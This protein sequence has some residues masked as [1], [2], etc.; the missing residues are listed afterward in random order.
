MQPSL[1]TLALLLPLA[2]GAR[3]A[4]APRVVRLD[5]LALTLTLP[6]LENLASP[7]PN[8]WRGVLSG[9]QVEIALKTVPSDKYDLREPEDVLEV[10]PSFWRNPQHERNDP[11]TRRAMA[12]PFGYA[13][14]ASYERTELASRDGTTKV[15]LRFLLGGLLASSGYWITLEATPPPAA[16]AEA[17]LFEFLAKGIAYDGP[18]REFTWTDEEARARWERDAPVVVRDK[19]EPLIRTA[20]YIV[21]TNSS[22][23]PTFGKKIEE[24][25]AAIRKVYPFDDVPGRRLLPVFLFRTEDEYNQFYAQIARITMDE[26]DRSKGH[27]SRDY[28]ATY[29]DAPGDPVH[30]HEA[31]HQ[32]FS[33][34]LGLGGG[35]SWFQEGVA[36]YMSTKPGD[37]SAVA[38][39]VKKQKHVPLSEFIAIESLLMSS[40]EDA[41]MGDQAVA[42]YEQAALL[43]EFLR[44]SKWAKDKFPAFL[45]RVGRVPSQNRAEIE[46]AFE[47]IYGVGLSGL[48]ERW[49]EYCKKR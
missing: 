21:L 9:S 44:E 31:T 19:L 8:R 49:V 27:A 36:E 42:G 25:F 6:P 33:N 37:R 10:G 5:D 23:G 14:Y 35:G 40:D 1:V 47:D 7:G 16:E 24:C 4:G 12:G 22:G 20:H 15:S 29:Y 26:A 48:E 41:P 32:I 18:L 43:I 46:A 34:R 28:Y 13:P 45:Q 30:I 17:V 3:Q 11:G 2:G 38:G 39:Q